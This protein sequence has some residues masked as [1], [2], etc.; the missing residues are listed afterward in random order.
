MIMYLFVLDG[1]LQAFTE[2]DNVTIGE[3]Q[4]GCGEIRRSQEIGSKGSH[5]GALVILLIVSIA[6]KLLA[7]KKKECEELTKKCDNLEDENDE[8]ARMYIE[9]YDQGYEVAQKNTLVAKEKVM[10]SERRAKSLLEPLRDMD[11]EVAQ[12][13]EAE[14]RRSDNS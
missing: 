13:M 14:F 8:W 1:S 9:A 5:Y 11:P 6:R 3:F 2:G 7:V 12:E 4:A 10:K